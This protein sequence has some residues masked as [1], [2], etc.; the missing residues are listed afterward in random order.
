MSNL[1]IEM[2]DMSPQM[3][4][5]GKDDTNDFSPVTI[6]VVKGVEVSAP[7]SPI[8]E[9]P[10]DTGTLTGKQVLPDCFE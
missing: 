9:P 6:K 5:K 7:T 2:K 3:E 8:P 10:E 1:D 4:T